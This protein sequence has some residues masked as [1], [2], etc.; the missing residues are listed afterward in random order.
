MYKKILFLFFFISTLVIS[1]KSQHGNMPANEIM[2][3]LQKL[4]TLGSILYFAAHPD[5]ENTR[6][7]AWLAQE[8]KYR[9]GYLSLTRGDGGQNL[10]GTEQ[11]IDLGLIRTQE[12]L[13]ARS[14]DKGEQ[15]FSS[16]YDF[17]FSKT[18]TETFDFWDKETALREAVWIIRK[19][20]PDVIINRFPPDKRGGHGHHQASA[21]LA[22]EAY[23]A[24]ADPKYFPEQLGTVAPWRAKRLLWN[25]ANF[26]GMNNTSE[27]QLKINIGAY[28]PLLGES[29]GEIAA[30]SR[31]Q[32]KS[33]GFGAA[34]SR[35]NSTEYFEHVA[36]DEAKGDIM[37]GITTS[38]DRIQGSADI[39]PL[40][41]RIIADFIPTEPERSISSLFELRDRIQHINDNYWKAQKI[42]EIE[43]IITACAGIWIDVS[44]K[45]DQYPLNKDFDVLLEVIARRPNLAVKLLKTSLGEVQE[46]L[47]T[48]VNWSL[49]RQYKFA[50]ITQP[51]WLLKGHSLGK[52]DVNPADVGYPTNPNPP[53]VTFTFEINGKILSRNQ[54]IQYRVVDP[55]R[56]EI[57]SPITIIPTLTAELSSSLLLSTNME[58]KT[59]EVTFYRHDESQNNFVVDIP[60]PEGWQ[61]SPKRINL[62]FGKENSLVKQI[63]VKPDNSNSASGSISFQWNGELLKSIKT[64]DYDHIPRITWFP[65]ATV[66]CKSFALTNP[67]KTIGYLPGAGDMIPQSLNEIG[68]AV[69]PLNNRPLS[70]SS[71]SQYDAVIVGIRYFN[72]NPQA[73]S[74]Q[75]L[76]MDYVNQGGVVLVQYNVNTKLFVDQIG[77]YPF[78]I[79]RDR[80]TEEHAK[81]NYDSKDVALTYPNKISTLDFDAWVQ[82]RGL[83]FADKIDKRYRTPLRINDKDEE[84]KNGSL[85]ITNYGKGKFV[86]T[87]LSFFRQLPAGVPGAYRLF[88]NLLAKEKVN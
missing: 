73:S 86:Y 59:M 3:R 37:E 49:S 21:I 87:S 17:G 28:S 64:I 29:Y 34:T 41:K 83:Y 62:E 16:A 52:F 32:H 88:V 77:P 8:R 11:G 30:R 82:E 44:T 1:A 76:L 53:S 48:N 14:I 12:L 35:G 46:N 26:G 50:Q 68:I 5:D 33:Q 85:L 19:F 43:D 42:K 6:L 23:L 78:A 61:V 24:A 58:Q 63:A 81:V 51:Y 27:D 45:A 72:I 65:L 84:S 20:R 60:Q 71:L 80:V 66:S 39:E 15:F 79:S 18:Y 55:V 47:A 57:H 54:E 40:I 70:A 67:V 2:I 22:H 25:T 9:T 74:T 4:N 7:I 38:W 10:I 13:A 75:K 69:T 56:G 31:S 36:G